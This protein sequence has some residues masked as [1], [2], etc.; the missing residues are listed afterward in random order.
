[1]DREI[2]GGMKLPIDKWGCV[3]VLGHS[4]KPLKCHRCGRPI[5]HYLIHRFEAVYCPSCGYTGTYSIDELQVKVY[6]YR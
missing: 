3:T 1:M 5:L 4:F 2:L 6:D